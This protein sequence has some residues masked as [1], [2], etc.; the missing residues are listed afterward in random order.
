MQPDPSGQPVTVPNLGAP[1]SPVS[2]EPGRG[3]PGESG[4]PGYCID[5]FDGSL[6]LMQD[7]K[8]TP[9]YEERGVWATLAEAEEAVEA[10]QPGCITER[11]LL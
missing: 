6:W 5:L 8:L 2:P 4:H 1:Q 9:Q 3:W 7:G 11:P 10:A